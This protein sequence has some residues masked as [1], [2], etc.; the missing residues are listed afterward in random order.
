[1]KVGIMQPYF[2]PYIGYFHLIKSVD[3][4]VLLDDVQYT[5]R[6][7][8]TRNRLLFEDRVEYL[9]LPLVK[10]DR[11]LPIKRRQ[12]SREWG[13]FNDKYLRKIDTS[14]GNRSNFVSARDLY[15]EITSF[16]ERNLF[17]FL[18]RSIGLT[19]RYLGIRTQMIRSSELG[20][21]SGYK[22]AA[23]IKAMCKAAE[24]THY[25]NAIGGVELYDREDFAHNGIVL[26]FVKS[27]LIPYD[28]GGEEF[29]PALSIIDLLMSIRGDDQMKHHLEA[30]SLF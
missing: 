8:I 7:W 26:N 22:A 29:I 11:L 24:A 27:D 30:Y 19:C 13:K 3:L 25:V 15:L 5:K 12:I 28:Q 9:T 6:S 1:M 16:E 20:D 21:F 14:Y 2:I 4:F 10:D 23:M 18:F 17:E